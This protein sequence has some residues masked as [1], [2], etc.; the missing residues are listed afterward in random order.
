LSYQAPNAVAGDIYA[1]LKAIE[2][3]VL[4]IELSL[5]RPIGSAGNALAHVE[6]LGSRSHQGTTT[7][8]AVG[9]VAGKAN[10]Q[11]IYAIDPCDDSLDDLNAMELEP[12][13]LKQPWAIAKETAPVAV[14]R[15][16]ADVC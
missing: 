3:R 11:A 14:I 10:T 2:D 7:N 1:R 4:A 15:T 13:L 5:Q 12:V 9:S 6:A 16:V 8:T